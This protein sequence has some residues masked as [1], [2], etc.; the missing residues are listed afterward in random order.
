MIKYRAQ[1]KGF[2]FS[3]CIVYRILNEKNKETDPIYPNCSYSIIKS[4]IEKKTY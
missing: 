1:N 4:T 2:L 3:G